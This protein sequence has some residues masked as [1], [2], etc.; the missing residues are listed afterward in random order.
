M[1]GDNGENLVAVAGGMSP[2]LEVWNPEDGSVK[3]LTADF[4]EKSV[5]TPQMVSVEQ[6]RKLIYY[7]GKPRTGIWHFYMDSKNWTKIGDLFVARYN[8]IALPVPN[9]GCPKI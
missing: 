2:G 4:P 1:K 8:S 7:D 6:G 9:I 3:V 5:E